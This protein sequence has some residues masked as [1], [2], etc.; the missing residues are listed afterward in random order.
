MVL[1]NTQSSILF[2]TNDQDSFSTAPRTVVESDDLRMVRVGQLAG[3]KSGTRSNDCA[4]IIHCLSGRFDVT[5][6]RDTYSIDAGEAVYIAPEK[7][8]SWKCIETGEVLLSYMHSH[9]DEEEIDVVQVASEESF[10]ASDPPAWT[11]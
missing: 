3:S 1:S 11:P 2:R 9:C 7:K 5:V 10:P 6:E 8:H 4:V